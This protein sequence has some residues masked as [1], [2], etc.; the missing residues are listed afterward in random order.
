MLVLR[1][2]ILGP[3][4]GYGIAKAIRSSSTEALDIEFGS[5]YP[6][7]KRLE[8]KGWIVSKWE[9]S[10]LNR[11]A[12]FYRLTAAGKKTASTG[13]LPM[14]RI[15]VRRGASHGPQD[16]G[17]NMSLWKKL[18][19]LVPSIRRAADRD[20]QEELESLEEI[21]GR[22]ELGNLT[23]AAEDARGE[24]GWVWVERL[25]QDLRYGLRSM[26]R[27]KLF[28]LLAVTSL[29]LGIGAN[30]A[31]YSFMD[32]ILMRPLPVTDPESLVVMKWHAK[33]YALAS[34][35]CPGRPAG[36]HAIPPRAR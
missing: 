35:E 3:L 19:Y 24:L 4:H 23:L 1:T 17:A 2:L 5:L 14:A 16:R 18:T 8:M 6:A 9:V 26:A 10:D 21:A 30:T 33:G 11:R 15:C 13:T 31:I 36:P 34:T 27:D 25:G 20:M 29:A 12:K 28:A 7:L 22:R 32:S